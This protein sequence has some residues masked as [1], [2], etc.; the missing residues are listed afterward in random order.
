M[1]NHKKASEIKS[2]NLDITS[3]KVV[4]NVRQV[5]APPT[6]SDIEN[7]QFG[8]TL[9]AR[10]FLARPIFSYDVPEVE[11]LQSAF[12]YNFFTRDER[13][14]K[15]TSPEE[16]LINLDA[17]N[18]SDI[19][20]QVKNDKLPR[21][22]KFSFKPAR[23]P[24]AKLAT[25]ETVVI[26]DNLDKIVIEGAG[27]TKYHTGVELLDT[28]LEK[29]IYRMMSGSFTFISAV[30]DKDSPKSATEKLLLDLQ[31]CT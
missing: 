7:A 30:T 25:G 17:D 2:T 11:N 12:V 31:I 3:R 26:R 13:I 23:D 1:I 22:V 4:S 21:Y 10:T 5:N 6:N 8:E 29:T 24:Y 20:Y 28:N 14:R 27:S 16:Q 18:T 9:P 19:F 15:V